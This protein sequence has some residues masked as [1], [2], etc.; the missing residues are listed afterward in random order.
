MR[1]IP[2]NIN[3]KPYSTKPSLL[4]F[5][6]EIYW[7]S[8]SKITRL[9]FGDDCCC[10]GFWYVILILKV[11]FDMLAPWK[12]G[13]NTGF[14]VSTIFCWNSW[15]TRLLQWFSEEGCETIENDTYYLFSVHPK[16]LLQ[17][18][19]QWNYHSLEHLT[20]FSADYLKHTI[21][22]IKLYTKIKSS[23][24]QAVFLSLQSLFTN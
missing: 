1:V 10:L 17:R 6:F 3:P 5:L 12:V 23:H 9:R 20:F 4:I 2:E 7:L 22:Y 16:R 13:G 11:Q 19:F 15:G 18:I 21:V 24:I 8:S 14:H